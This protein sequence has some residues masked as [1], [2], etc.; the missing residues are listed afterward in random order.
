MITSLTNPIIK[1]IM[2]LK[3]KKGHRQKGK[4]VVEGVHL[5]LELKKPGC[6]YATEY[7]IHS[8]S[9]KKTNKNASQLLNHFKNC[10]ILEVS[11]KVFLKISELA[12]PEGILA[13][14]T[15]RNHT[16]A[17][18]LKE[19]PALCLW[20]VEIQDPGNLG[21][22]F[23]TAEALGVKY[24]LLSKGSVDPFNQKA[25]RASMG[26]ILRIPF[27]FVLDQAKTRAAL[28]DQGYELIGTD[29]E[30]GTALPQAKF[31]FPVVI[32]LGSEARGLP[33]KL[34]DNITK[35]VKIPIAEKV[36]S[37]NVALAAGIVLYEVSKRR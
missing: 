18:T 11:D 8:A 20:G 25:I 33:E 29:A 28:A 30:R 31:N 34:V 6:F 12:N 9:F 17:T 21:T 22:I 16:I 32:I 10:R 26:S 19:K 14:L 35:F 24:I 5:L 3:S 4:F 7:I 2:L 37:L 36:E 15:I 27:T 13:V 1:E 23:R